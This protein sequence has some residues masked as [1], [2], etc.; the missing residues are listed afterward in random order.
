MFRKYYLALFGFLLAIENSFA[1][2]ITETLVD[3]I[4]SILGERGLSSLIT[5]KYVVF[6]LIFIGVLVG[7]YSILK[8]PLSMAFKSH[9]KEANVISI[10][11]SLISTTG[12]FFIL[13]NGEPSRVEAAIAIFGGTIGLIVLSI[14]GILLLVLVDYILVNTLERERLSRWWVAGMIGT[15]LLVTSVLLVV[16]DK[17]VELYTETSMTQWLSGLLLSLENIFTIILILTFIYIIFRSRRKSKEGQ[18]LL[19]SNPNIRKAQNIIKKI[20]KN[21]KKMKEILRDIKHKVGGGS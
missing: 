10:M 6:A 4:S 19:K 9:Q 8:I 16:I 2:T 7:T 18:E 12:M 17:T 5:N 15:G 14:F 21:N 3:T 13:T 20:N 11:I 1:N